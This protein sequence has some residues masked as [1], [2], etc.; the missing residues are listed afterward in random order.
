[1]GSLWVHRFTVAAA[2]MM[3]TADYFININRCEIGFH[4]KYR[5]RG[6]NETMFPGLRLNAETKV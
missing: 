6:R 1:M 4:C 3:M 5:A 2:V